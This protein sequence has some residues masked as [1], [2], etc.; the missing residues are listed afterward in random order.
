MARRAAGWSLYQKRG[1]YYVS[2]SF[3]ERRHRIALGTRDRGQA[4]TCA[5]QCYAETVSGRRAPL[6]KRVA[7]HD[8]P[9]LFGEW[10]GA[11][12]PL[13]SPEMS[14][15]REIHGR[16]LIT[17]F[18]TL[19][20]VTSA[21]IGDYQTAR[22]QRVLR[23]TLR[24]ELSTLRLFLRWLVEQGAIEK[25]PD[26]PALTSRNPGVRSGPQREAPV[27]LDVELI[28][29]ILQ[30]L[31]EWVTAHRTNERVCVKGRFVFTWETGLRPATVSRI[32]VP[33]NWAPGDH[34]LRIHAKGDKTRYK[35]VVPLS[36]RAVE[37]LEQYA[38]EQGLIFGK[39]DL[40]HTL[41]RVAKEV[42]DA[43]PASEF[44]PYDFRHSRATQLIE[45]G[46]PRLGVAE[47]LGHRDLRTTDHYT[48]GTY[49]TAR[50]ALA[51]SGTIL[52]PVKAPALPGALKHRS[53][54]EGT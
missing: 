4:A 2:F 5:A 41:K 17:F 20:R 53:A 44:S 18:E 19:D 33:E 27:I 1:F 24:K 25:A 47:L 54:K 14:A 34:V 6:A 40:R 52:S 7:L 45:L 30:R 12:A 31:P 10:I 42:I 26:F 50:A 32:S 28:E 37:M 8:L 22:L 3:R 51:V 21:S 39:H 43:Q 49:R 38:P 16:T 13:Y 36:E 9:T 35:R 11:M 15:L 23:Q 29:A 48:H 46:A